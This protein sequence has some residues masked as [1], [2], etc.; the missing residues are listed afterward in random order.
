MARRRTA[1]EQKD[2]LRTTQQQDEER[3]LVGKGS[4][5]EHA[6]SPEADPDYYWTGQPR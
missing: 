1:T 3:P 4:A 6:V 5:L 2:V